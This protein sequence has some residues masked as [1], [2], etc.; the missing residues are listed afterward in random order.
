MEIIRGLC[1]ER[2]IFQNTQ[3]IYTLKSHHLASDVVFCRCR[4]YEHKLLT[5]WGERS[6]KIFVPSSLCV[7]FSL[8]TESVY[9]DFEQYF[10]S[11]GNSAPVRRPLD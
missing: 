8:S 11:N 9:V 3:N 4:C 6:K 10:V 1:S 2:N 5:F 7:K